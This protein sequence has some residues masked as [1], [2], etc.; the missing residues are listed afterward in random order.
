MN[1]QASG[2][3]YITGPPSMLGSGDDLILNAFV[4]TGEIGAEARHAHREIPILIGAFLRLPQGIG[5]D[6]VELDMRAAHIHVGFDKRKQ[7]P[8]T[9]NTGDGAGVELQVKMYHDHE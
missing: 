6:H 4:Q 3:M 5:T 1:S 7:I 8:C 2:D 9:G